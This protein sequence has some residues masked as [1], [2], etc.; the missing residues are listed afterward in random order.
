MNGRRAGILLISGKDLEKKRGGA[1]TQALRLAK[2]VVGR[3][4]RVT[5]LAG[6]RH[7][8]LPAWGSVTVECHQIP[9][10]WVP[11]PP[12]RFLGSLIYIILV[13]VYLLQKLAESQTVHVLSVSRVAAC[14]VII[15]RALGYRVICRAMGMDVVDLAGSRG[16]GLLRA[17]IFML[18]FSH[19]IVAPSSEIVSVLSDLGIDKARLAHIPNGVDTSH[20]RPY[21]GHKRTLRSRLGLSENGQLICCVSRLVPV[22]RV[23]VVLEAFSLLAAEYPCRLLVIGDG[24]QREKLHKLADSLGVREQ[25]RFGGKVR[26]PVEYLQASDVFVLASDAEGHSN[27]LIEAMACGLPVVATAVGGNRDCIQHR[28][29]G[30]L[31]PPSAPTEVAKAIVE[32]CRDEVLAAHLGANARLSAV[33][34]YS[35]ERMVDQYLCAYHL[36]RHAD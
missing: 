2:G 12:V 22:K 33:D 1:E 31:V 7:W 21:P 3:G 4:Y 34:N 9:V 17:H 15:A 10:L 35:V 36:P 13:S 20:Y 29:N 19:V 16:H 32:V 25:V 23:D 8:G 11:R 27:A 26:D 6:T 5:I 14:L 28:V 30:L 18:R 24:E